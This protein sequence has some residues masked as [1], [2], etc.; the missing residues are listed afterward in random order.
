MRHIPL[1]R[2]TLQTV[3]STNN[4]AKRHVDSFC[5]DGITYIT[6]N[7]QTQGRG[8]F[9]RTWYSP[10]NENLYLTLVIP[11]QII[12]KACLQAPL[13]E[14]NTC[15][16]VAVLRCVTTF[17]VSGT[18]KLPNDIVT[19]K[20]KL[21]GI[22]VEEIQREDAIQF[23]IVGVGLNIASSD[24]SNVSQKATSLLLETGQRFSQEEVLSQF[25]KEFISL[26]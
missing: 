24:F 19:A 5:Q 9:E 2:F 1:H 20:G 21:S 16:T 7:K 18:I 11:L 8:R 26:L 17:G 15:A 4:W 3:D 25:L 10:A 6:T 22:L 23:A 12:S 13:M 14:L